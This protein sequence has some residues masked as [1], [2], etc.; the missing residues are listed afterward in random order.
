MR[1]AT[2]A[3]LVL[4]ACGDPS[5][6]G[7]STGPVV[8]AA[9]AS[10][11]TSSTSGSTSSTG[12]ADDSA[13]PGSAESMSTGVLRDVGAVEDFGPVQ[14]E[15]CKG[16]VDL[17]FLIS[18]LGT[19][20]TE[21]AQLLASFPGFVAT[22]QDKLADFDVH[23]MV[24]NPTGKWPGWNCEE[25]WW[26]CPMYAPHC[27]PDDDGYQCNIF[28]KLITPCDETLAAGLT[29]NAGN[30]A[31]NRRCE[32]YGGNRYIIG[33]EPYMDDALECIA[34]VGYNGGDPPMGDALIA[35]LAPDINAEGGCNA[36]FLRD[37]ALLV[38]VSI[39]DTEDTESKSWPYQQ[40]KAVVDAKGGDPNAIVALAVTPQPMKDFDQTCSWNNGGAKILD[41]INMFPY[42]V[43]GDTCAPSYAP[44]FDQAA[45]LIGEAC[46]QFVPQ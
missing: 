4:A 5:P 11:G 9:P 31:A 24:A 20:K 16:K 41:L 39:N 8:T 35:A 14:P 26:G 37:D 30:G 23:I 1:K 45:D 40:Y 17:L 42:H 46:G 18:S 44:F 13:G 36:G 34:K 27:A 21:Q 12:P 33:G 19:M 2:L 7:F 3:A 32:L 29:F 38:I 10:T 43:E 28:P 15:G 22:I 6:P 25:A